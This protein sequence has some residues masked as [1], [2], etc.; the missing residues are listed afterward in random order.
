MRLI[1]F[2]FLLSFSIT[3]ASESWLLNYPGDH[4]DVAQL[5]MQL[6][7]NG[8][9]HFAFHNASYSEPDTLM[10]ASWTGA[11]WVFED[12]APIVQSYAHVSLAI[13][14]AGQPRIA[15]TSY[16]NSAPQICLATRTEGIWT[17]D[18][19][20]ENASQPIL[21]FDSEQ[22]PL[23]VFRS[24]PP[25]IS[26]DVVALAR[27]QAGDWSSEQISERGYDY[28]KLDATIDADDRLH[29]LHQGFS[30]NLHYIVYENG[31]LEYETLDGI[32][33]AGLS[34]FADS[35]GQVH[36]FYSDSLGDLVH[37]TYTADGVSANE[38]DFPG[39]WYLTASFDDRNA[40]HMLSGDEYWIYTK[41]EWLT[42]GADPPSISSTNRQ[43]AIG[44]TGALHVLGMTTRDG[45]CY[46]T[47]TTPWS[48]AQ[49][50]STNIG[51]V[52]CATVDSKGQVHAFY[53]ESNASPTYKYAVLSDGVWAIS[54]S[55][56]GNVSSCSMVID[57]EDRMHAIGIISGDVTYA[58]FDGTSWDFEELETRTGSYSLNAGKM[59]IQLDS[60]GNPHVTYVNNYIAK[61]G[62]RDEAGNW[63]IEELDPVSS[64]SI[65]FSQVTDL[66]I[67]EDDTPHVVYSKYATSPS[68]LIYAFKDGEDWIKETIA[69]GTS[70]LSDQ[71]M[72]V[73]DADGVPN[74]L[75][76]NVRLLEHGY[77][78][79]DSWVWKHVD[80]DLA[81]GGDRPFAFEVDAFGQ[82]QYVSITRIENSDEV[83][84]RGRY[85][86][87]TWFLDTIELGDGSYT[88]SDSWFTVDQFGVARSLI[89]RNSTA[90]PIEERRLV[91]RHESQYLKGYESWKLM[92]Y[93]SQERDA[94]IKTVPDYVDAGSNLTNIERYIW[95]PSV[96][97]T[98]TEI[99]S[100]YLN[101]DRQADL[102]FK[103]SKSLE[104][105]SIQLLSSQDFET[106]VP[107]L[108]VSHESGVTALVPGDTHESGIGLDR[109]IKFVDKSDSP[110]S[111]ELKFFKL[112]M[113][114]QE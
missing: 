13:D 103:F 50:V 71:P 29:V 53:R 52:Q 19:V 96:L 37:R 80:G 73:L 75:F 2:F 33:S 109:T 35:I 41:G 31:E 16:L 108:S 23:I 44:P 3:S 107:L 67:G 112:E 32:V 9:P 14:D 42:Q 104:D 90:W 88:A 64:S 18:I 99:L 43:M 40:I 110:S 28:I 30:N 77:L 72:I 25:Q 55:D 62:S 7:S 10:Y 86:G 11:E 93:S 74:I 106:W 58:K 12:V 59:S 27:K 66:A 78:S 45:L 65:G 26:N 100:L 21:L 34:I 48:D 56:L 46:A 70:R 98:D 17:V 51:R 1:S 111:S 105:V 39:A 83:V 8:Q 92:N 97:G 81:G 24:G 76:L 68:E 87:K 102:Q 94:G 113:F 49:N 63:T 84:R 36:L 5:D 82:L 6:D 54:G 20:S 91:Y 57:D 89:C 47:T 101:G 38:V 4:L 79:G 22:N 15:Y 61:Y 95:Q 69:E 114:L 60:S 85:I